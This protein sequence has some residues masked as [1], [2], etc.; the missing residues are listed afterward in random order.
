MATS[1]PT[2]TRQTALDS[3]GTGISPI[4]DVSCVVVHHNNYPRVLA[5]IESA[6]HE[7]IPAQRLLVV[8]NSTDA[9][10]TNALKGAIPTGVSFK[11][12]LNK[13][14]GHAVNAGFDALR[15]ADCLSSKF[16]V[17]TH[18]VQFSP[19][20]VATLAAA[21]DDPTVGAAGPT[22]LD[23]NR[24][25]LTWSAGGT[26]SRG[27]N[28]PAHVHMGASAD[29]VA[30][31]P[32]VRRDWLDG[33]CVMYDS[34]RYAEMRLREDFFLYFE[35]ADLHVRLRA[36]G[37]S[38]LWVPRARASQSS[39]G[40]PAYFLTRNLQLFQAA[41]GTVLQRL[42]AVPIV[43]LRSAARRSIRGGPSGELM[44]QLRGWKDGLTGADAS[45]S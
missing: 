12:V 42:A 30:D 44:A 37:A 43:I 35:E 2:R 19:G 10:Q 7:G 41:H 39:D 9:V 27:L 25:G 15:E 17:I 29:E 45:Q 21:F 18:E 20:A 24:E 22:L 3:S 5:T 4:Q 36:T 40:V 33:A 6:L 13:G 11:H 28:L 1:E 16:L 26:L 8:D 31:A 34:Q 38:V 14:Y 23:A 32:S